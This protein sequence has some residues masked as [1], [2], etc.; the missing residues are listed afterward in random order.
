MVSLLLTLNILPPFSRVSIVK[1]QHVNAGWVS[2]FC[3]NAP[4]Y[5]HVFQHSVAS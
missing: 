2:P 3:V 1:F 4:F 5:F